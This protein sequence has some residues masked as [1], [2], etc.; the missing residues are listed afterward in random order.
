VGPAKETVEVQGEELA[1]KPPEELSLSEIRRRREMLER[2]LE[3]GHPEL[4]LRLA[5]RG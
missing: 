4:E 1:A 2:R 3:N 5:D